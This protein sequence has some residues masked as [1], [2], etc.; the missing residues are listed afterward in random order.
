MREARLHIT[1]A[2][3]V[4]R[5]HGVSAESQRSRLLCEGDIERIVRRR[6]LASARLARD[7]GESR[8]PRVVGAV[9]STLHR[10]GLHPLRDGM[11]QDELERKLYV[12]LKRAENEIEESDIK[13]KEVFYIPSLS[14][15][16]IVYKGLAAG[17]AD[18]RI[19]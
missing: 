10:A 2:R 6:R 15:Q 1:S 11:P 4:W 12:V 14:T 17:A 7:A 5:R 9:A 13:D 8:R 3:R 16:T 18:R 19:L